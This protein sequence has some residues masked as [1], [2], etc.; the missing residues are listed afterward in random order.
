MA[1]GGLVLGFLFALFASS[2][3][4][5]DAIHGCGG[6]I[7]VRILDPAHVREFLVLLTVLTCASI[8]TQA[9]RFKKAPPGRSPEPRRRAI[10]A[11]ARFNPIDR[12]RLLALVCLPSSLLPLAAIAVAATSL[13]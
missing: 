6:F 3:A 12:S 4:A 13:V 10:R 8:I 7:E 9:A 1:I 11:S 5:A 2:P